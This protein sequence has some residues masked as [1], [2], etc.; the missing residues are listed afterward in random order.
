MSMERKK[1]IIVGYGLQTL[2]NMFSQGNMSSRLFYGLIEL[3]KKYEVEHVSYDSRGGLLAFVRNNLCVLR[4]TDVVYTTYLY[5]QPF[6]LLSVLRLMGLYRRRK[7]VAVC[8]TRLRLRGG[9]LSRWLSRLVYNH[10]DMVLF[11]S[12][13]N[14]DESVADGLIRSERTR[15][16]LWG[17]ELDYIDRTYRVSSGNFFIS[18]GR[19][20]RD[21]NLL[22]SAFGKTNAPLELYTNRVNYGNNYESLDLLQGRYSNVNIEFVDKSNDTTFRL[23]QRTAE[24]LCVVIPLMKSHVDYCVGLTSIV[25][26]MALGKPIISS[27][28]PYSPV[29]IE[30][31]GIGIVADTE[32][33]WVAAIDWVQH[34][35]EE[36]VLMG[37]RARKLAEEKFNI[38]STSQMLDEV[39][40]SLL[41]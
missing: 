25:E 22:V 5:E 8:H 23:V 33:D 6:I 36:A 19:E 16:F 41:S 26:A 30:A 9:W 4:Q 10:L 17:D 21:F 24:S 2:R 7:V 11:H 14:L 3:E 20:N 15:F 34:H 1:I 32:A 39:L 12:Q 40:T 29:D 31:Q 38:R 28:N 18:T 37:R 13:R 27:P 35:P